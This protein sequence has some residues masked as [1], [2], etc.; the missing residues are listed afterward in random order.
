[1]LKSIRR[2]LSLGA[3]HEGSRALDQWARGHGLT[4]RHVRGAMGGI[5]EGRSGTQPWRLEWGES[6]RSYIPGFEARFIAEL[7]MPVEL[8]LL[9]LNR[10][11]ME[12]TERAA[13]EQ[14]VDDVQTRIDTEVPPEMRWLILFKKLQPFEMGPLRDR[15][16]IACSLPPWALQWLDPPLV[17]ALT[18]TIATVSADQPVVVTLARRRLL[19]RT[20]MSEPDLQSLTMWMNVFERAIDSTC[21]MQTSWCGGEPVHQT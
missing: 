2:L 12:A 4:F 14:Y 9:L 18:S 6:Q 7:D 11:L 21:R 15:Y 19:L 3:E 5:V 8:H 16:G 1:M 13:Y 10:V 17:E 20:A